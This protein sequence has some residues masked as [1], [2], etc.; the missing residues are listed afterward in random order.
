MGQ[1]LSQARTRN[2]LFKLLCGLTTSSHIRLTYVSPVYT[3]KHR[4]TQRS[5]RWAI[6]WMVL[7][8]IGSSLNL[9]AVARVGNSAS[10]LSF[11]SGFFSFVPDRSPFFNFF[12]GCSLASLAFFTP[13]RVDHC[14]RIK[15]QIHRYC[16]T[17]WRK[18]SDTAEQSN[19]DTYA[20]MS[21]HVPP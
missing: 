3:K 21:M 11:L 13:A 18:G 16:T 8:E 19:Q 7:V 10:F 9:E 20:H 15:H 5:S 17:Q 6:P 12:V 14:V 2:Q 1:S 4:L